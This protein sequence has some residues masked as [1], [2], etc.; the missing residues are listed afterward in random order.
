MPS[1]KNEP[2]LQRLTASLRNTHTRIV[3]LD[4]EVCDHDSEP[5][6]CTTE[7]I[8][9]EAYLVEGEIV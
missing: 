6:P 4:E 5:W 9:R 2:I 3:H 8:L 7:Q 1:R